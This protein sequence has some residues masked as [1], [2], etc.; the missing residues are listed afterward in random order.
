M[1]DGVVDGP[2]VTDRDAPTPARPRWFLGVACLGLA[3]LQVL[4]AWVLPF[5]SGGLS[6]RATLAS[7][8]ESAWRI[9]E[10]LVPAIALGALGVALLT[11]R[12]WRPAGVFAVVTAL[13]WVP[14]SV[15][16]MR[17]DFGANRIGLWQGP[18]QLLISLA[19]IA[20]PVLAVAL[21]A[22][23]RAGARA[24]GAGPVA[25]PG[26]EERW[27]AVA[28]TVAATVE[29]SLAWGRYEYDV[30]GAVIGDGVPSVEAWPFGFRSLVWDGVVHHAVPLLVLA[31]LGWLI[32]GPR[33]LSA[34]TRSACWGAVAVAL[35]V[36]QGLRLTAVAASRS[37]SGEG[38]STDR[39]AELHLTTAGLVALLGA[40]I[41]FV[42]AAW[43]ASLAVPEPAAVEEPAV[44]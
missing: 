7:L 2:A 10:L 26:R 14:L 40:A 38:A 24:L 35:L 33:G 43:R 20:L 22:L 19:A 3:V 41:L 44:A 21:A 31:L 32:V 36:E 9:P 13:W 6:G 37:L 39:R 12:G 30:G 27:W 29:W 1:V 4:G 11:D 34:R 18:G 16:S 15:E 17:L 5:T 42:I 8:L 25:G 23:H 28:A